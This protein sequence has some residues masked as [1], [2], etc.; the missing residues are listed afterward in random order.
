MVELAS[1]LRKK[2][3]LEKVSNK[4]PGYYK[5]WAQ[6]NEFDLILNEL[7]LT[8][9]DIDKDVLKEDGWYCIYIGIAGN[10]SIRKRLKWHVSDHHTSSKIKHGTLSTLRQSIS[11]IIAHDQFA[12]DATNEFIDKL[13][14][15]YHEVEEGISKETKGK[16]E[17]IEKKAMD[18][19]WYVLNI[20]CNNYS[21]KAKETKRRLKT[22]RKQSKKLE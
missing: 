6:Q 12:E 14:I 17:K 11:S 5:W 3:V 9:G 8:L 1:K 2:E 10:E 19:N 13:K 16:L 15:E 21:D 18:A 20:Q 4:K 22:L 7:G